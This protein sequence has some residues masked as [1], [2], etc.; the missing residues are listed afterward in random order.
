[1]SSAQ[2]REELLLEAIG[3][4]LPHSL[5][6]LQLAV[7]HKRVDVAVEANLRVELRVQLL[8]EA[9]LVLLPHSLCL[10]QLAKLEKRVDRRKEQQRRGADVEGH[11][12]R[13]LPRRQ[14]WFTPKGTQG[15]TS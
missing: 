13:L 2:L 7:L 3:V 9:I 15:L 10:L 6:L 12:G 14:A 5:R 8:L 1:M 4:L 11:L